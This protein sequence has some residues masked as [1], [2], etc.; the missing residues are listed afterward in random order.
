[1]PKKVDHTKRREGIAKAAFDVI[2]RDGI[3]AVTL[4]SVAEQAHTSPQLLTHYIKSRDGLLLAAYSHFIAMTLDRIVAAEQRYKGVEALRH[5]LWEAVPLDKKS[6]DNFRVWLSYAEL[7]SQN[8]AIRTLLNK[9]YQESNAHYARIIKHAQVIGE[10]PKNIDVEMTAWG[11]TML[12]VGLGA[13]IVGGG[14]KISLA[15]KKHF[16]DHW[17]ERMLTPKKPRQE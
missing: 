3:G 13:H 11:A 14:E 17:I 8:A 10:V 15:Q 12:V 6:E 5:S 2:A 9:G 1:M 4:R 7:A 16:I